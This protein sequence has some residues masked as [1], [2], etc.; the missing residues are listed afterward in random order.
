MVPLVAFPI[1]PPECA[2]ASLTAGWMDSTLLARLIEGFDHVQQA[3]PSFLGNLR[4]LDSH[5]RKE[6]VTLLPRPHPGHFAFCVDRHGRIIGQDQFQREVGPYSR[7]EIALDEDPAS[8]DLG[9]DALDLFVV[10]RQVTHLYCEPRAREISDCSMR[11]RLLDIAL[12]KIHDGIPG[13]CPQ[14]LTL[15][16]DQ[17]HRFRITVQF[18]G[19]PPV[20]Q[21][22][23]G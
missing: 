16:A 3:R 11:P 2:W 8:A 13:H 20:P 4:E 14:R 12:D 21:R 17:L 1:P 10:R 7:W 9:G 23:L 19:F 15:L 6:R 22:S 5:P 18:Q